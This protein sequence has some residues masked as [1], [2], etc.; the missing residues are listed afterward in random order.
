LA[1]NS[2]L[3]KS[4]RNVCIFL[5]L[6]ILAVYSFPYLAT[7][8]A[9]KSE[10]TPFS[11]APDL[12]FYLNL[13][14]AGSSNLNC[15][16]GTAMQ[17]GGLGYS[18]F[19]LAFRAFGFLLKVVG[20]NLWQA[21]LIWSLLWW[22]SACL[23]ALW[24]LLLAFPEEKTLALWLGM[25]LLFF[26]NF[27]AVKSLVFAWIHVPSFAGFL[28]LGLPYI[29]TFF[30]PI[31]VAL[32]FFYLALQLRVLHFWRWYDLVAM[33]C[34]QALGFG[35]FPYSTI[36]MA[37]TTGVAVLAYSR[38]ILKA[39]KVREIV[40]YG[41]V[42]ASLDLAYL[43]LHLSTGVQSQDQALINFNPARAVGLL[44]GALLLLVLLTIAIAILPSARN[45]RT[46]YTM[47]GFG[48]AN[49][50]LMLGDLV[51]SPALLVSQHGGYFIH[52]TI[53]LQI[54]YLISM[55]FSRIRRRSLWLQSVSIAAIA[56]ITLNGMVLAFAGY[57][58]AIPQNRTRNA[59]AS[60]L[61]SASL[62]SQDLV[63]ARAEDAADDS[64]DWVPVFTPARVLFCRSAQYQMSAA[65]KQHIYRLRQAFYLYFTGRDT[66]EI[67]QVLA[68]QANLVEQDRLA[69]AGEIEPADKER[70]ATARAAIATD[71]IPLL[72]QVEQRGEQMQGFF[73]PYKRVLVIDRFGSARFKRSQLSQ[74]LSIEKENTLDDF[75]LLW[76]RPL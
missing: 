55:L 36:A 16:F 14:L 33:C 66:N 9:L 74:Y 2:V 44:G 42:C 69:F 40:A 17:P 25:P 50:L 24:F 27:G 63:I 10:T 70:W 3:P 6:L 62:T 8:V 11:F 41:F 68:S 46:K 73:S 29:R 26:F 59:L 48:V 67:S 21:A 51:F 13:S 75:V 15:Y 60:A 1:T 49:I 54:V 38:E 37:I 45:R 65:E 32:L 20:G 52:S 34:L 58:Y 64:C 53:S 47:V 57:Q 30:P 4:Q 61:R 22:I 5:V 12:S 18:T 35:T 71:L 39:G 72:L 56:M 19:D 28:G 23:G 43:R 76:C 7:S 31:P